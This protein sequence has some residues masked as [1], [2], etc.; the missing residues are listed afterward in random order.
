MEIC[1]SSAAISP[2][3]NQELHLR[4]QCQTFNL[5]TIKFNV[6]KTVKNILKAAAMLERS[7]NFPRSL[8]FLS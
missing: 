1:F 7:S 4:C 6:V 8:H 2:H 3:Q 5:D